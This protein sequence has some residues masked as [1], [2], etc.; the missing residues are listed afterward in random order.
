MIELE[1][2]NVNSKS[3]SKT[4]NKLLVYF[5][6]QW[7]NLITTI[8]IS[9]KISALIITIS[10]FNYISFLLN[11]EINIHLENENN[12][13]FSYIVKSLRLS[14]Y[15]KESHISYFYFNTIVLALIIAASLLLIIKTFVYSYANKTID[16]F[17][18]LF[19]L[20]V[21][22][23]LLMPLL[24]LY[25]EIFIPTSYLNTNNVNKP[26]YF[27]DFKLKII[28]IIGIILVSFI[29]IM[30]SF[31]G[32]TSYYNFSKEDGFS[33][34]DTNFE[35]YYFLIRI[36]ANI[37]IFSLKII[38]Y[39]IK[40]NNSINN[41]DKF[42]ISNFTYSSYNKQRNL[43]DNY[44]YSW[45]I[46]AYYFICSFFLL[47]FNYN[48]KLYY[49]NIVKRVFSTNIYFLFVCCFTGLISLLYKG[50]NPFINLVVVFIIIYILDNYYTNYINN[51]LIRCLQYDKIG[52][53]VYTIDNILKHITKE[54]NNESITNNNTGLNI[55]ALKSIL[56]DEN[57]VNTNYNSI[58]ESGIN[59]KYLN[60]NNIF[61]YGLLDIHLKECHYRDCLL[62]KSQLFYIPKE[63]IFIN[64]ED[65]N[66]KTIKLKYILVLSYYNY[67]LSNIFKP[68]IVLSYAN[69]QLDIVGNLVMLRDKLDSI[70]INKCSIQQ[71]YSVYRLKLICNLQLSEN[72]Y[73]YSTDKIKRKEI[74]LLL[75]KQLDKE[76][77]LT[78]KKKLN[79]RSAIEIS[80]KLDKEANKSD[81]S[82]LTV[83]R[84]Y[85]LITRFKELLVKSTNEYLSFWTLLNHKTLDKKKSSIKGLKIHDLNL[86][87]Y[88]IFNK[89]KDIYVN[90]ET[91]KYYSEY[92]KLVLCDQNKA[93][94]LFYISNNNISKNMIFK[95][96]NIKNINNYNVDNP[97]DNISNIDNMQENIHENNNFDHSKNLDIE[98]I[99]RKKD[100]FFS[101]E[102]AVVITSFSNKKSKI[103]K[104]TDTITNIFGYL[105][106]Q[107]LGKELELLMPPFFQ[108]YHSQFVKFHM[109][110]GV[111]R[112]IGHERKLYGYH[113]NQYIF[114]LNINII[115]VPS[116]NKIRYMGCI[117]KAKEDE[118]LI[119]VESNGKIDSMTN[120]AYNF[121][122]L[123]S[124]SFIDKEFYIYHLCLNYIYDNK[125]LNYKDL[126]KF[127]FNIK[128]SYSDK[129]T[130]IKDLN[131][132]DMV[133][134]Y[135]NRIFLKE[136]NS[137]SLNNYEQSKYKKAQELKSK[138]EDIKYN[139]KLVDIDTELDFL[140]V[141]KGL[142][143]NSY[144]INILKL[145][146]EEKDFNNNK[147]INNHNSLKDFAINK[148]LDSKNNDL[149]HS[150]SKTNLNKTIIKNKIDIYKNESEYFNSPD[151]KLNKS[152][153]QKHLNTIEN[154]LLNVSNFTKN[155]NNK[156]QINNNDNILMSPSIINKNNNKIS[157][158][159]FTLK[160]ENYC[161]EEN[162]LL[163]NRYSILNDKLFDKITSLSLRKYYI[164]YLD[165]EL[166]NYSKALF[167]IINKNII[168]TIPKPV[169]KGIIV[170][171][172]NLNN[173]FYDKFNIINELIFKSC[174]NINDNQQFNKKQ[175]KGKFKSNIKNQNENKQI[176][177]NFNKNKL[178]QMDD[179]D[180]STKLFAG[181]KFYNN[182]SYFKTKLYK[183][184]IN[185]KS[186]IKA[187]LL[188]YFLILI[189][190][191]IIA[192]NGI[193]NVNILRDCTSYM[194][195]INDNILA[196]NGLNYNTE[197]FNKLLL[198]KINNKSYTYSN[199]DINE[200]VINLDINTISKINST[201]SD[202]N[203]NNYL[204][205]ETSILY[206]D[207]ENFLLENLLQIDVYKANFV[208]NIQSIL[209]FLRKFKFVYNNKLL[210][211]LTSNFKDLDN[212]DYIPTSDKKLYEEA[213]YYYDSNKGY[214]NLNLNDIIVKNKKFISN[215][216]IAIS[217]L[218]NGFNY[219]L[220][221]TTFANNNLNKDLPINVQSWLNNIRFN[222]QIISDK[223]NS[224]F[225]SNYY[226]IT[227]EKKHNYFLLTIILFIIELIIIITSKIS[228]FVF[229]I[230]FKKKQTN[231]TYSFLEFKK[232]DI[233][234]QKDSC[235]LFL[236]IMG[237]NINDAKYIKNYN[238]IVDDV[239][240]N[241]DNIDNAEHTKKVKNIN[242]ENEKNVNNPKDKNNNKEKE[243]DNKT[244]KMLT[245]SNENSI[246]ISSYILL[247]YIA[248][249]TV[250]FYTA[251]FPIFAYIN[252]NNA[253]NMF[254]NYVEFYN[255]FKDYSYA[256]QKT[257]IQS[258]YIVLDNLI[259]KK[260]LNLINDKISNFQ[261]NNIKKNLNLLIYSNLIDDNVS[262][263]SSYQKYLKLYDKL[264]SI[265]TK[266][267][268]IINK[269]I[270][271]DLTK[272]YRKIKVFLF[273]DLCVFYHE[274]YN[275]QNTNKRKFKT[276]ENFNKISSIPGLD[277]FLKSIKKY[278]FQILQLY[279]Q[280]NDKFLESFKENDNFLNLMLYMEYIGYSSFEIISNIFEESLTE[281]INYKTN[282]IIIL[283]SLFSIVVLFNHVIIWKKIVN[284]VHNI[285]LDT[286]KIFGI[287]PI[288]YITDNFNMYEY[289]KSQI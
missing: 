30:Y 237:N 141:N 181:N 24:D 46:L 137:N 268:N 104:V 150:D 85:Y 155:N 165:I 66:K 213:N 288:R 188:N 101:E 41:S 190:C 74:L 187:S 60:K 93:D 91:K 185:K 86:Q 53:D 100:F 70:D 243:S 33:R 123:Q 5:Y 20:F 228:I 220:L 253:Y 17:L 98:A 230:H 184:G 64:Q 82:L 247:C 269:N 116:L 75:S 102:S 265:Q 47:K 263:L 97:A 279:S 127:S 168:K 2:N 285:K 106:N 65:Y 8:Y 261:N 212:V 113:K 125:F 172:H 107:L 67:Y 21:Y 224:F 118:A 191:S 240:A 88:N 215:I 236:S 73:N 158:N 160:K 99:I 245:S 217:S 77:L 62:K 92:F 1:S 284:N 119:L 211:K 43:N 89:I 81:V 201:I 154:K 129:L 161:N 174:Q 266:F 278:N 186:Y 96:N 254:S 177:N 264:I 198:Y 138:L 29:C 78:S 271:S 256:L 144:T 16:R 4:S 114:P 37:L 10:F 173:N 231:Q 176:N 54:F 27:I 225:D 39:N 95:D 152:F 175:K 71:A 262:I 259:Y 208:Y 156:S 142:K 61:F 63:N 120:L 287:I 38:E 28:S 159:E 227:I 276:C 214:V 286:S 34:A 7:D 275:K 57:Y 49:S 280:S 149:I 272:F 32:N 233:I 216:Y 9:P 258:Q 147:Y 206:V 203:N 148:I 105:P 207:P 132:I 232:K 103:E 283:Y 44:Y 31:F 25:L 282:I 26:D 182:Y 151:K 241:K 55:S 51:K 202:L 68:T 14:S 124:E 183:G 6:N 19:S 136:L 115:I 289:L 11:Y 179:Q 164:K 169:Y 192:F 234:H 180:N 110:T 135:I 252:T 13:E 122:N 139:T 195:F 76:N 117:R 205:N 131:T 126:K 273:E 221:N 80:N 90:F 108:R 197:A 249:F 223:I 157:K 94:E 248:S 170:K 244:S 22:W 194:K 128:N 219:I 134:E 87:I 209:D 83:I 45:S 257:S 35:I 166:Y 277:G 260:Q 40:L 121:L 69:Y 42:F 52:S 3:L 140:I 250:V 48:K 167:K 235:K 130:Y 281:E 36:I 72:L 171:D 222:M 255:I 146:I 196:I 112:L 226:Q 246:K 199:N 111:R 50:Y 153:E 239:V 56:F 218:T 189:L 251:I 133:K 178:M 145:V 79:K 58:N 163:N 162:I 238:K 267:D 193:Y 274:Y 84:Y 270:Y 59:K 242:N 143:E 18:F 204:Y 109:D 23:I 210:S 200:D 12:Y 229:L 15:I